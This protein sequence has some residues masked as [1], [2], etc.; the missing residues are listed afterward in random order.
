MLGTVSA[1]GMCGELE[2]EVAHSQCPNSAALGMPSRPAFSRIDS[3]VYSA[4][5]GFLRDQADYLC[6]ILQPNY[7][8]LFPLLLSLFPPPALLGALP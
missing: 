3:K 6:S 2:V 8:F 7:P 1:Q 5:W 4:L